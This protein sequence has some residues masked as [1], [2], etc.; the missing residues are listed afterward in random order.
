M[1]PGWAV[2]RGLGLAIFE[3]VSYAAVLVATAVMATVVGACIGA[4]VTLAAFVDWLPIGLILFPITVPATLIGGMTAAAPTTLFVLP[5]TAILTRS[6]P[7][8]QQLALPI[9]GGISG[10]VCFLIAIGDRTGEFRSILL[11]ACV[12]AGSGSGFF[13]AR[14]MGDHA[15]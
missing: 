13:F 11:A 15:G 7:F 3:A 8:V 1:H 2:V 14:A 5:L 10:L 4:F 9:A 12:L 6:R